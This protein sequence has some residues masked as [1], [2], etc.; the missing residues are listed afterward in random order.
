MDLN[1]FIIF[2]KNKAPDIVLKYTLL[3][4][5]NAKLRNYF[6]LTKLVVKNQSSSDANAFINGRVSS[7]VDQRTSPDLT[8]M[9]CGNPMQ[10]G[11]S[12]ANVGS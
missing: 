9:N 6:E 2:E 3:P 10:R 8:R 1:N 5:A 4:K 12:S 7:I 11:S